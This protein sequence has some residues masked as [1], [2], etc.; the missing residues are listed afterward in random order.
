MDEMVRAIKVSKDC[1]APGGHNIPTEVWKY[2][3]VNLSHILH[4]LITNICEEGHEPK[5][6]RIPI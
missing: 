6:G 3:V 1:K 2:W 4:R 5:R